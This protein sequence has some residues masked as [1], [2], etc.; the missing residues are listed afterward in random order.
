[1]AGQRTEVADVDRERYDFI[2]SEE[3]TERV[4]AGLTPDIIREISARKDEPEW[5]LEHRLKCLEIYNKT[6]IPNWGPSL[7]GLDMA[8]IVTYVK[9]K[10]EQKSD[11]ESVP[12]D[13]KDTFDRLGIP[14]AERAYLAGVG[15]QYDSEL[16]YHNIQESVADKGIVYSGIE[17]AMKDG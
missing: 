16:V 5:M 14:Q 4:H 10:G 9:P 15:A 2:K 12:E 6:P 7:D 17:E 13:I 8:N 11:W 3:G 1:M